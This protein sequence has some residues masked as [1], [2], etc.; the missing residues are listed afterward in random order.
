[1]WEEKSRQMKGMR[2]KVREK[3]VRLCVCIWEA[4]SD[5]VR[6]RLKRASVLVKMR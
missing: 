4:P 6:G 5:S 3:S 2:E 1:M